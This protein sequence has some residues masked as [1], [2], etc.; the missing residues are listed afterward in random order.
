MQARH[1]VILTQKTNVRTTRAKCQDHRREQ[2]NKT[3][4]N[5]DRHHKTKPKNQR[6]CSTSLSHKNTQHK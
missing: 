3:K 6:T 2:K 4:N 1:L 5:I